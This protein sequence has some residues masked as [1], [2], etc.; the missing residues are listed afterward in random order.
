MVDSR[1]KNRIVF[2]TLIVLLIHLFPMEPVPETMLGT[3]V[4]SDHDQLRIRR[5][6]FKGK[7]YIDIRIF[8]KNQEGEFV[9]TK[10]GVTLTKETLSQFK[11]IIPDVVL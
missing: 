10:K 8:N 2:C 11:D 5:R 7:Q 1:W 4:R 6:L 3:I 9:P